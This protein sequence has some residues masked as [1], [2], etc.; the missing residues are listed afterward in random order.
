MFRPIVICCSQRFKEELQG[1][2]NFLE[3]K[4]VLV[5]YPDFKFHRKKIIKKPERLRPKTSPRESSGL[6]LTHLDKINEVGN[7]GG[8]CLIFN[9][10]PLEGQKREYGYVGDNTLGEVF[11]SHAKEIPTIML[12]PTD[13][14]CVMAI[15]SKT[16]RKRIF[17][18][19][20]PKMKTSD[21]DAI[22][23][24]WLRKWLNG[25]SSS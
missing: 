5:F 8:I 16:E 7:M 23:D 20:C 1:F 14:H 18:V 10:L 2:V 6:V 12:K 15:I 13:K 11:H 4:G 9:P 19:Q 24:N 17:T 25:G 21:H 22:W 3:K